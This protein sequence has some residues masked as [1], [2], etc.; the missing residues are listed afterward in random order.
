MKPAPTWKEL[1]T[2]QQRKYAI[3]TQNNS[4]VKLSMAEAMKRAEKVYD[5]DDE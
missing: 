5:G 1:T 4:S 3:K 2:R